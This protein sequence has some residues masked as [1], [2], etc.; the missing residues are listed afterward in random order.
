MSRLPV[1]RL[2]LAALATVA[3]AG[4]AGVGVAAAADVPPV[5]PAAY[6][7]PVTSGWPVVREGAQNHPVLTLQR[8]L[9]ARGFSLTVDGMFGPVTRSRVVAFQRSR[10]LTADG[11]V[12]ARTWSALVVTVRLRSTGEAVRALEE[13]IRFRDLRCGCYP[14]DGRFGA[15]E[16]AWVRGFQRGVGI[17]VDGVVGPVTWRHLVSGALAG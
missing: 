4:G 8:L 7:A 6:A 16:D 10:G 2:T 1:R 9:R 17:T 15:T 11:V 14:V 12:G 3:V 5:T 13:E